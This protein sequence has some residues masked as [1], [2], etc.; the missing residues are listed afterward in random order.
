LAGVGKS[1]GL[2]DKPIQHALLFLGKPAV[3]QDGTA[4]LAFPFGQDLGESQ[5]GPGTVMV[6]TGFMPYLIW[7]PILGLPRRNDILPGQSETTD[8]VIGHAR[9]VGAFAAKFGPEQAA[10]LREALA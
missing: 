3:A 8:Q 1:P 2:F 4:E 9:G 7:T 10:E 6:I 5:A